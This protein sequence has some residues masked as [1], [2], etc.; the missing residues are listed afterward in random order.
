LQYTDNQ[1]IKNLLEDLAYMRNEI[2]ADYGY[3]FK[4]KKWK[5]VFDKKYW[6]KPQ[7]ENV[8]KFLTEIDKYNLAIIR[9]VEKNMQG[10]EN[11]YL[12]KSIERRLLIP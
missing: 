7:Y 2:Y 4:D 6:Y 11:E 3:I 9:E 12:N 5:E 8:D 10:K 1:K